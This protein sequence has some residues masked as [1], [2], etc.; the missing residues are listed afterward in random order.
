MVFCLLEKLSNLQMMWS[1]LQ[2]M[3]SNASNVE[4]KTSNKIVAFG[5]PDYLDI[6]LM[7]K[8]W[9]NLRAPKNPRS[10]LHPPNQTL[11]TW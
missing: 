9:H 8:F 11:L 1:Y 2:R 5:M 6:V 10:L 7:R 3:A 4:V